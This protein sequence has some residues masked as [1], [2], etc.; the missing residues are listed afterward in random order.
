MSAVGCAKL[1]THRMIKEGTIM[2]VYQRVERIDKAVMKNKRFV[3]DVDFNGYPLL[4]YRLL[5]SHNFYLF[6]INHRR[7]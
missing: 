6:I 5:P 1:I 2:R 7:K 4:V 3:R